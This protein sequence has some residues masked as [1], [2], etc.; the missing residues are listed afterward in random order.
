MTILKGLANL[1]I[2]FC[3]EQ[4]APANAGILFRRFRLIRQ[5]AHLATERFF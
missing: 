5:D 1:I 3:K 4:F 2:L